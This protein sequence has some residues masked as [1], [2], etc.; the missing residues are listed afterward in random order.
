M[1][2]QAAYAA[3]RE[4]YAVRRELDCF[5]ISNGKYAGDFAVLDKKMP[6]LGAFKDG[7]RGCLSHGG[8]ERA[9]QFATSGVTAGMD[10]PPAR[11]RGLK[12]EQKR[13]VASTVESSAQPPEMLD[14][15]RC[16]FDDTPR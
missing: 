4:H 11:M 7:D 5:P 12:P 16:R 1:I 9:D 15:L 2:E 14:R 13:A 3:G 6:N 8:C 10:D